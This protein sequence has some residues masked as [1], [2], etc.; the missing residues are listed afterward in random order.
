MLQLPDRVRMALM[1]ALV[2]GSRASMVQ[3]RKGPSTHPARF[4]V[5]VQLMAADGADHNGAVSFEL[6]ADVL[7]IEG[8]PRQEKPGLLF[9]DSVRGQL[10]DL[11]TLIRSGGN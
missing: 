2:F 3:G 6:V 4:M 1:T 11:K 10:G 7:D 5:P 8:V 9:N